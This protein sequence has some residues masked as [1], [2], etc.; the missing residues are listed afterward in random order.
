MSS[1]FSSH[2]ADVVQIDVFQASSGGRVP[3]TP[4]SPSLF[5][6]YDFLEKGSCPAVLFYYCGPP[7]LTGFQRG[8]AGGPVV[9]LWRQPGGAQPSL[10]TQRGIVHKELDKLSADI[11]ADGRLNFQKICKW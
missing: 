1:R 11:A 5:V 4:S 2:Q 3:S 7:A 10:A 8:Q 6:V 9:R